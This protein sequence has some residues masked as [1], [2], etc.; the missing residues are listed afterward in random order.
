MPHYSSDTQVAPAGRKLKPGQPINSIY[1][2]G[3][4][5]FAPTRKEMIAAQKKHKKEMRQR[6]TLSERIDLRITN[7]A[8]DSCVIM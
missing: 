3:V 7:L 1:G 2:A 6:Y 5:P 8:A 4:T